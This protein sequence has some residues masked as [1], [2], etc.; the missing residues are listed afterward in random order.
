MSRRIIPSSP[1]S[2]R[3]RETTVGWDAPLSTFFGMAFDPPTSGDLEDDEVEV[4]WVGVM[5]AEVPTVEALE[6]ELAKHSVT[7]PTGLAGLLKLD[8]A[9]EG[10]SPNN[11]GR[12]IIDTILKGGQ[13]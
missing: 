1:G 13:S 4:F 2:P 7:L 9:N 8:Q 3:G 6:A 12:R 11:P 10:E 5:P